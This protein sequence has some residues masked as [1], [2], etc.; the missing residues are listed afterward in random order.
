MFWPPL[1]LDLLLCRYSLLRALQKTQND[2]QS[3]VT[4]C[5]PRCIAGREAA[6]AAAAALAA[7]RQQ[8]RPAPLRSLGL[9]VLCCVSVA[10]RV[11]S[12]RV[13]ASRLSLVALVARFRPRDEARSV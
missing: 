5:A 7:A 12:V 6:A 11:C 4:G 10:E 8:Q 2:K 1:L 13:R 9:A 3:V